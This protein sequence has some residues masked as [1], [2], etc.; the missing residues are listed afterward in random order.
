MKSIVWISAFVN[1]IL[2]LLHHARKFIFK[3][4][5]ESSQQSS[6]VVAGLQRKQSLLMVVGDFFHF[7]RMLSK[8]VG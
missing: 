4:R 5:S 6:F 2:E 8:G 1:L 7:S 3:H